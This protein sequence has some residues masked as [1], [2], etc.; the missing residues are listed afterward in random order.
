MLREI[1]YIVSLRY[2]SAVFAEFWRNKRVKRTPFGKGS[3]DIHNCLQRK[4]GRGL[5]ETVN[6]TSGRPLRLI[7]LCSG[8][9]R[10]TYTCVFH[11]KLTGYRRRITSSC[12]HKLY[13]GWNV[14]TL[15]WRANCWTNCIWVLCNMNSG[16][17]LP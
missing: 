8:I 6:I 4:R 5:P 17:F 12:E 11:L 1:T 3:Y 14:N 7:S 13:S 9:Y 2:H 16:L 10:S 15:R